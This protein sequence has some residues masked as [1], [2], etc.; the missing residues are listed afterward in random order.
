MKNCLERVKADKLEQS[1]LAAVELKKDKW[2]SPDMR[3][4]AA[5]RHVSSAMHDNP[6]V[7]SQ[8]GEETPHTRRFED[9]TKIMEY[10]R[11][12]ETME[13]IDIRNSD[14]AYLYYQKDNP[15]T[16]DTYGHST[17]RSASCTEHCRFT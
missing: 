17:M 7:H 10:T 9:V 3:R 14:D 4:T 11:A 15:S 6:L 1:R 2:L 5:S 8:P 12:N 16:T 13:N